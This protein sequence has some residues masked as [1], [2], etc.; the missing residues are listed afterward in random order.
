MG[1]RLLID[2]PGLEASADGLMLLGHR[3]EWSR[4]AGSPVPASSAWGEKRASVKEFSPG[5][6]W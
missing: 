2:L 1:L 5:L 6:G 3:E 4:E